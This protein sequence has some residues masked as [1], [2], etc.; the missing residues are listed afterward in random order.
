MVQIDLASAHF[1]AA[2]NL[3]RDREALASEV[4]AQNDRL[5]SLQREVQCKEESLQELSR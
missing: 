2:E 1:Q 3:E 5:S 4:N